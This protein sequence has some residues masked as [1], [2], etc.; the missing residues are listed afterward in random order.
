MTPQTV[1][2][3]YSITFN[4]M[5]FPAAILQSPFFHKDFPLAFNYGAIGS[6]IGHEMTHGFD[7]QGREFD[8][9]GNIRSWWSKFS[10]DN[11]QEKTQCFIQQYSNLSFDGIHIN[12]ER[13]LG[14]NIAD[15]GGLKLAY[16]AYKKHTKHFLNSMNN[17]QLPAL[18]YNPDQLFFIAFAY[19]KS[20]IVK[21]MLFYSYRLFRVGVQWKHRIQFGIVS[22]MMLIHRLLYV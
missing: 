12:A 9:D 3:Y 17:R 19:V 6:I 10:S 5:I 2:A 7:N 18:D 15:N 11:F 14:E 4:E 1:N 20:S 13:S 16:Y 21:S 22:S 8:A